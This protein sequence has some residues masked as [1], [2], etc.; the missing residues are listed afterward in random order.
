[1]Y[2]DRGAGTVDYKNGIVYL[3]AFKP[4]IVTGD[5]LYLTARPVSQNINSV[6]NQIILLAGSRIVVLNDATSEVLARASD[7][8]TLGDTALIADSP[9]LTTF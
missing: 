7:L 3:N 2:T 9:G 1:M 5:A 6:R 8:S 4:D